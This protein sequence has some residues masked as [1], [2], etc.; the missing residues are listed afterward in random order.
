MIVRNWTICILG[1]ENVSIDHDAFD[2]G[3]MVDIHAYVVEKVMSVRFVSGA[4]S[5]RA[6]VSLDPKIQRVPY[7]VGEAVYIG[8]N[9]ICQKHWPS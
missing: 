4:V 6:I 8:A 9:S 7:S 3:M 5:M 1:I 2:S